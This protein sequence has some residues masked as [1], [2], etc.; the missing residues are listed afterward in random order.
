MRHSF[1]LIFPL[2]GLVPLAAKDHNPDFEILQT[3]PVPEIREPSGLCLA[4]DGDSLYVVGD[5]GSV[6]RIS[7]D[8]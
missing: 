6:A 3:L 4:E 7:L 8:G 1:F 5:E 2:L